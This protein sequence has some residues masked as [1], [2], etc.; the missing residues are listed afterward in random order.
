[1]I[2]NNIIWILITITLLIVCFMNNQNFLMWLD[3]NYN[4]K[5]V[6][7]LGNALLLITSVI[8]KKS[9]F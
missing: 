4:F 9:D 5:L 1:M 2:F 3:K 8:L 7:I 6:I